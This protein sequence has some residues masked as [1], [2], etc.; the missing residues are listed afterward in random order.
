MRNYIVEKLENLK[1]HVELDAFD[2]QTP[3]GQKHFVNIIATKDPKAAR[4]VIVAAHFDS[5]YFPEPNNVCSVQF[6]S[7]GDAWR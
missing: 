2:D 7:F 5:K 6:E 1:W 3:H 4:R